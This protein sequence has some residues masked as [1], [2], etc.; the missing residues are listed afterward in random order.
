MHSAT[1]P[2]MPITLGVKSPDRTRLLLSGVPFG[3]RRAAPG[4]GQNA[5]PQAAIP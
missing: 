4:V 2:R 1:S 5:R 3:A